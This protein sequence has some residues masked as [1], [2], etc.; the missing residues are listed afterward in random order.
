MLAKHEADAFWRDGFIVAENAVDRRAHVHYESLRFC[1]APA[2]A[3]D[4]A[5]R[6]LVVNG[7]PLGT[8]SWSSVPAGGARYRDVPAAHLDRGLMKQPQVRVPPT[9]LDAICDELGV[10]KRERT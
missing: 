10:W 8:L 5:G 2:L 6:T 4:I 7:T 3:E 1:V 9:W